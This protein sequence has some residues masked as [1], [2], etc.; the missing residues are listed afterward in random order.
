[1]HQL[2]DTPSQAEFM[3]VAWG[4]VLGRLKKGVAAALD[5]RAAVRRRAPR[6]KRTQIRKNAG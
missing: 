4:M 1:V 2:V 3:E 6:P 5:P